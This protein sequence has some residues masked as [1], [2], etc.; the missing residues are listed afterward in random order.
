MILPCETAAKII[1][2]AIRAYVARE[3]VVTHELKQ[4]EVAEI[5]G[6]TQS[7]VSKY[8]SRVRGNILKI[9][10]V[11]EAK[12]ML[13]ELVTL[14]VSDKKFSRNYFLQKFC[15]TCKTIRKTGLMCPLCKKANASISVEE[16]SF[17]MQ[18]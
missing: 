14:A 13:A 11:Q 3:L 10:D 17:C 7:A 18:V 12:P 6:I 9:E 5:L 2:P 16:C 15:D 1:I 4:D 8:A